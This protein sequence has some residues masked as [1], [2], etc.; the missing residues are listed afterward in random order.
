MTESA[1]LAGLGEF[2]AVGLLTRGLVAGAGVELGPGDDA[3]VLQPGGARVVVSTDTMVEGVHFR[4]DWGNGLETGRKAVAA[5][6]A[7]LE[8]MGAEPWALVVS[9][10]APGDLPVTWLRF[11]HQGVLSECELAGLQLVGGD[12]TRGRDVTLGMTVLGRLDGEPVTRAGARPGDVVAVRGRLGWAAAGL[13]VLTRGFRSPRAAVAAQLVPEVP[14]GAGGE[15]RRAGA[16]AMIDVSDGLLADL[17][18]VARASG[19]S[20]DVEAARLEVPEV[21]RTVAQATGKDALG[22][23][24]TGGEDHALAACFPAAGVP[25]GWSVVGRVV[26]AGDEPAV[27]VDGRRWEGAQGHD[28]F[29]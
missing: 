7:D 28:H 1:T 2:G 11:F 8:A 19:V 14:W 25:D 27:T 12:T 9:L 17:G 10:T 3:A 21:L 15:A 16:S 18:H 24:L 5:A 13:A 4:R 22:F 26:E 23:V 20:V 29:A 6:A